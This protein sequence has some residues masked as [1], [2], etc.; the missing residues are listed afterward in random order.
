MI[1]EIYDL[2]EDKFEDSIGHKKTELQDKRKELVNIYQNAIEF[3]DL[4]NSKKTQMIEWLDDDTLEIPNRRHYLILLNPYASYVLTLYAC[5]MTP[6]IMSIYFI[7][8]H[9]VQPFIE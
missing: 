2:C 6:A 5:T 3:P 1:K 9:I 8:F 4:K 7:K